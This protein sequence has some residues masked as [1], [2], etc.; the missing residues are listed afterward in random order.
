MTEEEARKKYGDIRVGKFP[1]S[2]SGKAL[3]MGET[4]GFVKVIADKKYGE[5]LGVHI[6]GASATEIIAEA[7]AV[8]KLEGTLEE[9]V[10]TIHAHPTIAETIM[11]AAHCALGEPIH[12]PKR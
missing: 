12:L 11:E 2:A 4:E 1:M 7:A 8:M 9:L 6:I 10:N 5:I 3:A